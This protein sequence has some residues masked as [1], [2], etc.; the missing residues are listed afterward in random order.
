MYVCAS[1]TMLAATYLVYMSKVRRYTLSVSC[2]LLKIC[3]VFTENISFGR[4]D[5]NFLLRWL[6]TWLFLDKNHT[7][8]S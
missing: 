2:G 1:V 8:G 7:N 5:V 3:I 6:A 4:Y